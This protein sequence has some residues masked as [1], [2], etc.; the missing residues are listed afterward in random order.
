M[1]LVFWDK[2]DICDAYGKIVFGANEL[3]FIEEAA[4]LPPTRVLRCVLPQP[5]GSFVVYGVISGQDM[6]WH[7]I[8]CRTFDGIHY[9]NAETVFE[10]EP[11]PWLGETGIAW[12]SAERKFLC[13]KWKLGKIGHAL[14]AFGSED[15]TNWKPLADKPV[16][17]D[18]DAFGLLWDEWTKKYI[19]YQATYQTWKKRYSD[20]LGRNKRRVLH[21]R[22]S[23]DGLQWEPDEDVPLKGPYRPDEHLITP[24]DSDSPE[25]EFYRFQVF[26]YAG[27]Y[28]GM[29]LNYAPSPQV[30]NPKFPWA[31][32]GPQLSGEWWIS[33]DGFKWK[34]PFRDV[35]APGTAPGIVTHAPMTLGGKHLWVIGRGVYG[36]PEDHLFFVGSM[37]NAEFSTLPFQ[38]S[39]KPLVLNASN[40]YHSKKDRGMEGQS[41][42]MVEIFG[43]DRSVVKGFA[44]K[45]CILRNVDSTAQLHWDGKDGTSLAG[46]TIQLRFYLR[47]ARIYSI[48][49]AC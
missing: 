30:V 35:F 12:N 39:D 6:P 22:T 20:N 5:D 23:E 4:G 15:G 10:S 41:Y 17:H 44:K 43:K 34:R 28:V 32:H 33:R 8:R 7:I 48:S 37:A 16:Y 13:L 38:M 1:K 25:M 40:R 3:E 46:Q 24:D 36:L 11:G 29:M 19:V 42:I 18:H 49:S 2:K 21:I 31:K 26:P 47:D 14:W 45:Q 9:E 27:R